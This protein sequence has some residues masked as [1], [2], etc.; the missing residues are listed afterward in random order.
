MFVLGILG[1]GSGGGYAQVIPMEEFNIHLTGDIHAV[2]AATNL[3]AAQLDARVFHEKT[4]SDK[5]L[6]DRLVPVVQGKRSFSKIQVR[7][8][9]T[10]TKYSIL[11]GRILLKI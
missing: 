7:M 11:Q 9:T 2:T 1:G 4:Q 8:L 3:L 10:K 6:Y 5:S